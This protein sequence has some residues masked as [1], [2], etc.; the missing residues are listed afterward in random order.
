M[1]SG[2][3]GKNFDA[4]FAWLPSSI[5]FWPWSISPKSLLPQNLHSLITLWKHAGRCFD[6]S[7]Q[8]VLLISAEILYLLASHEPIGCRRIQVGFPETCLPAVLAATA[9]AH[10]AGPMLWASTWPRSWVATRCRQR[11]RVWNQRS[12]LLPPLDHSPQISKWARKDAQTLWTA[13]RRQLWPWC[14]L[15]R[16]PK[17]VQAALSGPATH[18]QGWPGL[19][20]LQCL[21][22]MA[23]FS[24]WRQ[25]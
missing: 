10:P 17:L 4:S 15:G 2:N 5:N 21:C 14:P 16:G 8:R 22:L 3:R 20:M 24:D 1:T 6:K 25:D 13:S 9:A 18:T 23:E 7:Q 12:E 19:L 11:Q